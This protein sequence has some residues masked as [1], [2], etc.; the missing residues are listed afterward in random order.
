MAGLDVIDVHPDPFTQ[1]HNWMD[2]AIESNIVEPN[3][4]T[5]ATAD[6]KGIPS[7]RIVLLKHYD[8]QGF[9]FFTNYTSRKGQDI[10][11]N[12]HA[13]IVLHWKELE[14]Q[15]CIRGRVEKVSLADSETYF[16]M[17]PHKSQ[18]GAVA[19]KQSHAIPDRLWLE[20]REKELLQTYPEGTEIPLPDFW[21]GYRIIPE[22]IEF[23]QGR[24]SRLHDRIVYTK[25]AEDWKLDRLS[26]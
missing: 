21:G 24:T 15:V 2:L 3:A 25:D 9:C 18:I 22:Y 12:P 8:E 7:A 26:P 16:H 10:A 13:S 4:M 6:G 23:W 1:F 14:R 5:L 11:Q 19:S 17:R 20:N